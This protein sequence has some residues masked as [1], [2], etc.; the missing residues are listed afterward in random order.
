MSENSSRLLH[1]NLLPRG[2]MPFH[3]FA[4]MRREVTCCLWTVILV[5]SFVSEASGQFVTPIPKPLPPESLEPGRFQSEFHRSLPKDSDTLIRN[6]IRDTPNL[7]TEGK[8]PARDSIKALRDTFCTGTYKDKVVQEKCK[9]SIQVDSIVARKTAKRKGSKQTLLPFGILHDRYEL[10]DYLKLTADSTGASV[11]SRFAANVSDDEAYVTSDVISGLTGRFLFAINY[12]AV[13]VKADSA[14][15]PSEQRA[16]ES[17]KANVMRM[18][19][20]GGTLTMRGQLPMWA[21]RSSIQAS[22]ASV[23]GSLGL[24]GPM[25]N[26]DSLKFSASAV[27]EASTSRSIRSLG[28]AGDLLGELLLAARLGYAWSEDE[29]LTASGDQAFG[30]LQG[31]IGL[32]QNNRISLSV[33]Y[34]IPFESRYRPFVPKLTVNLAAIR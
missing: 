23:Y 25:G 13:V 6:L 18:I 17:Q 30:Y 5:A 7:I 10:E 19:N 34:T 4:P 14:A 24:V 26:T 3:T 32:L 31:A 2:Y 29:L 33:L 8:K 9:S 15:T 28:A 11:F 22:A 1:L 20:N 12:A 21:E 27:V 16:I